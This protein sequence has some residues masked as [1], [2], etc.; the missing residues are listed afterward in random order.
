MPS[1]LPSRPS[2]EQLRNEAQERLSTLRRT[3]SS[4]TLADAQRLVARDYGFN[5][6]RRLVAHVSDLDARASQPRMSRLRSA[7]I[8]ASP[9]S[10]VP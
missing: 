9:R 4:V 8:S 1:A 2:L 6:W 5:S 10:V 3:D 7:A